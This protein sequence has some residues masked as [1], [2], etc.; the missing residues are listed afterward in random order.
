MAKAQTPITELSEI[1]RALTAYMIDEKLMSL[2]ISPD[3]SGRVLLAPD[4]WEIEISQDR[5]GIHVLLIDKNEEVKP[6]WIGGYPNG[7]IMNASDDDSGP[8]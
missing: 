8:F 6:D 4:D 7:P 3:A 5:N 2:H 1:K